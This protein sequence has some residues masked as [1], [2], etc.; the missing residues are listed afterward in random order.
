MRSRLSSRR[1]WRATSWPRASRSPFGETR[2]SPRS[3]RQQSA[4]TATPSGLSVRVC[5][6]MTPWGAGEQSRPISRTD[7]RAGGSPSSRRGWSEPAL[8]PCSDRASRSWSA[9]AS[10]SPR[11]SSSAS[12]STQLWLVARVIGRMAQV[13]VIVLL[14]ALVCLLAS[15]MLTASGIPAVSSVAAAAA[16]V[17]MAGRCRAPRD[18][19]RAAA[20]RLG[21]CR[22]ARR[23]RPRFPDRR[24]PPRRAVAPG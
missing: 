1:C 20:R 4:S 7:A 11:C 21:A 19:R 9:T 23:V 12:G 24:M 18:R 22:R 14:V 6:R 5:V 13:A 10:R 2:R 3:K 15:P 16:S 8:S 17:T